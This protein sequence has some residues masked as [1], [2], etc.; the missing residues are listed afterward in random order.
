MNKF[1]DMLTK[2]FYVLAILSIFYSVHVYQT[3]ATRGIFIGLWVPTLLLLG[4]SCPWRKSWLGKPFLKGETHAFW[5]YY[6]GS[7]RYYLLH[8]RRLHC[9]CS[10]G[11][12]VLFLD[13]WT[14][15]VEQDR[16][17]KIIWL[18]LYDLSS[19][20]INFGRVYSLWE[21]SLYPRFKLTLLPP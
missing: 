17:I 6:F 21:S 8:P 7:S 20:D 18:T 1:F 9:W 5:Y 2:V 4:P 12:Q 14:D 3:D 16:L 13:W 10:R 19:D 11:S 15:A